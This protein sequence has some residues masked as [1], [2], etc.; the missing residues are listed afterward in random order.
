MT[1]RRLAWGALPSAGTSKLSAWSVPA[2]FFVRVASHR[3][4][5]ASLQFPGPTALPP[6]TASET[7]PL[8]PAA[9]RAAVPNAGTPAVTGPVRKSLP[10]LGQ[11]G[12]D[13]G[14][15]ALDGRATRCPTIRQL[16]PGPGCLCAWCSVA[17][18]GSQVACRQPNS[19]GCGNGCDRG[20]A[21][22][23]SRRPAVRFSRRC[24]SE[25]LPWPA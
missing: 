2:V 20:L 1:S 25:G 5:T 10:A 16:R 19:S 22:G 3:P 17:A 12:S 14:P 23:S 21:P 15:A 9:A 7:P 13:A 11:G 8:V 18:W 4:P 6:H 24:S